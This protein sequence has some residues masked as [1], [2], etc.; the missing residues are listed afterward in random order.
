[1]SP[2]QILLSNR[3][4]KALEPV[5]LTMGSLPIVKNTGSKAFIL[6]LHLDCQGMLHTISCVISCKSNTVFS[7]IIYIIFIYRAFRGQNAVGIH[8]VKKL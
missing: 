1:M 7:G 5:F 8:T 4:S 2:F 6:L 3:I